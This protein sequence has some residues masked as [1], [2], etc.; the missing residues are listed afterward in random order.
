MNIV[1]AGP[2]LSHSHIKQHLD[3]VCLPPV[4]HGNILDALLENPV[5]IGIIDGYFEGVPSV[6][7]KE[8]L[9][10]MDQG[11]R[12]YGSAS[13]GALRAAEL[14]AFGM[15]GVGQIFEHYRDGLLEDDDEVAVLH[16][17]EEAGFVTA[18][19]PLVNIRATLEKASNDHIINRSEKDALLKLAKHTFYK[20]R[21]WNRLLLNVDELFGEPSIR[22]KLTLWLSQHKVDQKRADAVSM[23]KLMNDDTVNDSAYAAKRYHFQW[24]SVWDVAFRDHQ[25]LQLSLQTLDEIDQIVIDQLRLNPDVYQQYSDKALL[26]RLCQSGVDTQL[27]DQAL[28]SSLTRFRADNHLDSRAQLTD[29]MRKVNLDEPGLTALLIDAA[30][31]DLARQ[32]A[33]NLEADIINQLKID[34][35]YIVLLELAGVHKEGIAIADDNSVTSL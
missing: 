27:D 18:S 2:T 5:A 14:S 22:E 32:A 1:Y 30:R 9:Y 31:V 7:H 24:T 17:P 23:L 34:G 15:V 10:A 26:S 4:S 13:M 21:S 20:Q 25:Q 28:K 19:V 35:Q 33:G 11:V 6:W 3:C 8:I 12:V 16:G 29:Y